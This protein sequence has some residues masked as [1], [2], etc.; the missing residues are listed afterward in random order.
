MGIAVAPGN[1][2]G[3]MNT[4]LS[5]VR[6]AAAVFVSMGMLSIAV[7]AGEVRPS[8]TQATEFVA[9]LGD[10]AISAIANKSASA[11]AKKESLATVLERGFELDAIGKFVAGNAWA[12]ATPEQQ[13]AYLSLFRSFVLQKYA[14]I[15]GDYSGQKFVVSNAVDSGERDV[16]VSSEIVKDGAPSV[17]TDWRVRAYE[18][19]LK[20]IDVNVQGVSM[21]TSQREEFRAVIRQKGF[22]GLIEMLKEMT[23]ETP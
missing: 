13:T 12:N 9:G 1:A 20:I 2:S 23:A 11:E 3:T 5:A 17:H 8:A 7:W 21:L 15:F 10:E 18:G 14:A 22:D 6:K 4:A 16:V 19:A